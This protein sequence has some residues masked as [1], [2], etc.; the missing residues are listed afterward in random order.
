MTS[1]PT[2]SLAAGTTSIAFARAGDR[3]AHRVV[4][5]GTDGPAAWES[6][7]GDEAVD[8]DGRW[9]R[10]PPL[11]EVSVVNAAGRPAILGVGRAGR[12]HF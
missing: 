11:T 2:V 7:E 1:P 9:P 6:E 5:V 8:G 12:S 4:V 3:W 10:S